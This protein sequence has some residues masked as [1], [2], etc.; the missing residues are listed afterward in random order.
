MKRNTMNCSILLLHI[1]VTFISHTFISLPLFLCSNF[2][3]DEC[4]SIFANMHFFCFIFWF[5]RET[6]FVLLAFLLRFIERLQF[7]FHECA[8]YKRDFYVKVPILVGVVC[9]NEYLD[10][11]LFFCFFASESHYCLLLLLFCKCICQQITWICDNSLIVIISRMCWLY[12]NN[13]IKVKKEKKRNC[14]Y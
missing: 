10:Y 13:K 11:Y 8:A 7:I 9:E 12:G 5:F 1:Y 14:K 2:N 3:F 4:H 6:S